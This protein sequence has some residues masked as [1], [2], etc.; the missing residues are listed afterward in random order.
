VKAFR[1][2]LLM[3]M[4]EGRASRSRLSLLL[5]AVAVGVA[6]LVAVNSFTDNLL[7]SVRE[8]SR[9]L[10][11]ADLAVSSGARFTPS[12]EEILKH[13]ENAAAPA[14]QVRVARVTSFAAMAHAPKSGGTRLVQVTALE[15][16]YP[17]Y[18]RIETEPAA[19][20][21][22]L[23]EGGLVADPSLLTAIGAAVGDSVVL[24]EARF[25]LSGV[26]TNVPGDVAV[27]AAFGPRAY[28]PADRVAETKLLASG[29]RA[30]Y[31]AYFRL[32]ASADAQRLAERFRAPLSGERVTLRTVEDD[33]T[34]LTDSLGRLGRYLGLVALVALL[35]G[36]LGVAS[37]AHVFVRRKLDT[38]AIL[39]CLG[40]SGG[41][42]M[43]VYLVQS[44]ALGILGSLLGALLGVA[45]QLV[46]PGLLRDLL[47]VDVVIAPSWR[48]IALGVGLG[49]WATMAFALLP[50]LGVRR[51]SPLAVLRR[52][53]EA[54]PP[55]RRDR[56]RLLAA[57][58]LA[59]SIVALAVLQAG[60]L[61]AG[62][63][64]AGGIGLALLVLW[65]GALALVRGT[66]RFLPGGLP[67]LVRQG[68]ANLHRPA[69]QTV[70]VVVALGFGA[71]LLGNVLLLQQNLLRELRV[72]GG[73]DRPNMAFFDIQT[74]QR[75]AMA[76][77]L[78]ESGIAPGAPVPIVPMRIE[79]VKG[80]PARERL[81]APGD[82]AAVRA[83]WALRREYRSSYRDHVT[84]SE[85][86]VAGT[87]WEPGEGDRA[88]PLPVSLE[89]GL[90]SELGVSVGDE[91]VW[92]VQGLP[93]TST[94]TSLREVNWQRFEPNFFA[95]FP[96]GPL[97]EA[98]QSFVVLSR[99]DG[100]LERGRVQRRLAERLP[101]VSSIDLSQI[102]QAIENLLDRVGLAIRFMAFFSLAAGAV[103]LLGAVAASRDQRVREGVLLRT[104]G[105]TRAQV[106]RILFSEYAALGLLSATLASG[107]CVLTGW[108]LTRFVFEQGFAVP[109]GA[110]AALAA[111]VVALTLLVG[112]WG[113]AEAY[114]RTPAD[115]LRAE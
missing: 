53:Y 113:G 29:S 73:G 46:L 8:Q 57:A 24:G 67:Y 90:A 20:W 12:V 4:R 10:L 58:V 37:A 35:L 72:G 112:F 60:S 19:A 77:A 54:A 106:R 13:L 83:R 101:N 108:A 105:A 42:V 71:F 98:P 64:F 95:I 15:K 28:I 38:I 2:V 82:A 104:L 14:G 100:A 110:I 50:L 91:I 96:E 89:V 93:V 32:P 55:A 87:F 56:G 44:A 69:N 18:G 34:R 22:R 39:R 52:D 107:L 45:V 1:F 115:A 16:G 31:E 102:Q 3:A 114:R 41:K 25:I 78:R 85:R 103:V 94:V 21:D 86:V 62:L 111:C 5:V 43:A 7:E 76:T 92:D 80:V 74:D 11:G 27:R 79:S 88:S 33:R 49:V 36:G 81:A 75:Q 97:D 6:A 47:P 51:V 26:V 48:A 84:P 109:V 23:P 40:A 70:T 59:L 66:R 65:L 30:R 63:G 68:L 99:I 17:F 61:G 9:A